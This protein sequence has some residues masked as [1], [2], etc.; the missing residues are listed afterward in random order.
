M[1]ELNVYLEEKRRVVDAALEEA[2]PAPGR[3]PAIL[4]EA[5]RY[6]V[7]PGGKRLRPVLCLAA[8]EAAGGRADSALP[9]ALAVELL[10]T[11][12]LVHDDLPCMDDDAM[13]RGRP[14]CHVRYGIANA[15][16]AGD[17]LQALAFELAAR[18]DPPAPYPA[19][20]VVSEL[21]RA[22]GSLGVV[23][24]QVED[25]A[26]EDGQGNAET[27][28][29]I[30]RHKTADLFRAALRMGAIAVGSPAERLETL[31]VYGDNL[32]LAFQIADDL[33]DAG[34]LKPDPMSC[35][36]IYGLAGA[37]ER[38]TQHVDRAVAA[39]EGL[40]PEGAEPLAAVARYV[41]E[42]KH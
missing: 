18:T 21:A 25:I 32:G 36:G 27:V 4:H 15:V 29:F 2:L 31:T 5:M 42:R 7:F 11:Y 14:T 28:A 24:G 33:L 40:P 35:L 20:R 38:A 26:F 12:T 9:A 10:H 8:A 34:D 22:A 30:H 3:R 13:R 19:G 17:A 23:G 37:R 41:V 6:A 16:L 39:L 1:F